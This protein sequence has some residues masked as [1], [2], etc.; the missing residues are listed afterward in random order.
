MSNC[1]AVSSSHP[2]SIIALH[3]NFGRARDW[4]LLRE[5]LVPKLRTELIAVDLWN[6]EYLS[7][8]GKLLRDVESIGDS[9][10]RTIIGY[11]MGGRLGVELIRQNPKLASCLV[12]I[13]TNPGAADP[14]ERDLR[15]ERD[16]EWGR[17]FGDLQISWNTLMKDWN[18]QAV[19][20]NTITT[21]RL[22]PEF[23]RTFIAKA[24][25]VWSQGK[26]PAAWDWLASAELPILW[27]TGA[28]DSAA[29]AIAGRVAA[30]GNPNLQIEIICNASHRVVEDQ[31]AILA[32]KIAA[33]IQ[34]AAGTSELR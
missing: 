27:I 30:L 26:L 19:F 3:G 21:E 17:R 23:S 6:D 10:E 9:R 4:D 5:Y 29:V 7:D 12:L 11:S 16:R 24:F 31:P 32:E 1:T 34:S 14:L 25:S 15:L 28:H 2:S 18:A 20:A 22:E 8:L 13:S 33:F